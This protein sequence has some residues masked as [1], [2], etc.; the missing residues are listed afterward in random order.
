MART[1]MSSSAPYIRSDIGGFSSKTKG[2]TLGLG[3]GK[4][5]TAKRHRYVS[6]GDV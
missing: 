3:K 5:K 2:K 4:S 1:K 6:R